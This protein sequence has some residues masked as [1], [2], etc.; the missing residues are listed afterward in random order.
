MARNLK[1]LLDGQNMSSRHMLPTPYRLAHDA[2]GVC[3]DGCCAAH[4]AHALEHGIGPLLFHIR[5]LSCE[6]ML[7][8]SRGAM[9]PSTA[10]EFV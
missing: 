8:Q 7:D 4:I 3:D 5:I 9:A 1:Q 10:D 2:A 6:A